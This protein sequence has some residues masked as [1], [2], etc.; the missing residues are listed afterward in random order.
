M[1]SSTLFNPP[2]THYRSALLRSPVVLGLCGALFVAVMVWVWLT[3]DTS[4]LRVSFTGEIFVLQSS[5]FVAGNTFRLRDIRTRKGN[6]LRNRP[7]HDSDEVRAERAKLP[8]R[9]TIKFRFRVAGLG[10]TL[11][12]SALILT[13][14]LP[15]LL[16]TTEQSPGQLWVTTL[17]GW[18]CG[19][20]TFVAGTLTQPLD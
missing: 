17:L 1:A 7:D 4:L 16:S 3:I 19:G 18:V 13:S 14:L 11:G 8:P 2:E 5:A 6:E 15:T 9:A 10:S 12:S 20:L